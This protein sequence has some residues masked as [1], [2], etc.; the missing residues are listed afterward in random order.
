MDEVHSPGEIASLV[1]LAEHLEGAYEKDDSPELAE[2]MDFFIEAHSQRYVFRDTRYGAMDRYV[3]LFRRLQEELRQIICSQHK[4]KK[5]RV[6]TLRI[7]QCL[8]LLTRDPDF[9]LALLEKGWKKSAF[10]ETELPM[11]STQERGRELPTPVPPACYRVMAPDLPGLPPPSLRSGACASPRTRWRSPEPM[12]R[13]PSAEVLEEVACTG[14]GY[15]A[16]VQAERERFRLPP[17]EMRSER[18]QKSAYALSSSRAPE[19]LRILPELVSEYLA[20]VEGGF[21]QG[22][23]FY[24]ASTS[25][26]ANRLAV[27]VAGLCVS[28]I[29]GML[30][31]YASTE[32]RRSRLA[33]MGALP[34]M[35]RLLHRDCHPLVQRCA[36]ETA[37]Q[38]TRSPGVLEQLEQASAQESFKAM[39]EQIGTSNGD[40]A[41]TKEVQIGLLRG[42]VAVA[43]CPEMR[44]GT[45]AKIVEAVDQEEEAK[46][47]E[48]RERSRSR[49]KKETLDRLA[50]IAADKAAAKAKEAA[51]GEEPAPEEKK[52]SKAEEA[53]LLLLKEKEKDHSRNV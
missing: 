8:R 41:A 19:V 31:R 5:G 47:N 20:E 51:E 36:L 6:F 9:Q 21:G 34:S 1:R 2:A 10:E 28:E 44:L 42:C 3:Q 25:G 15:L 45:K 11:Q 17:L 18:S 48:A 39:R 27:T 33:E 30:N 22:I 32:D 24:E 43:L 12:K 53:K 49:E 29:A 14:P 4:E 38:L 16:D 50:K 46:K 40:R 26:I 13:S 52:L 35:A 23:Q 7:L 37:V